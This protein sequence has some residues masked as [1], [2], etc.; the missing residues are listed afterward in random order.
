MKEIKID[1]YIE[2]EEQFFINREKLTTNYKIARI[3]LPSSLLDLSDFAK[4]NYS[5]NCALAVVDCAKN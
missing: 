2:R 1:L 5:L 4:K 3:C